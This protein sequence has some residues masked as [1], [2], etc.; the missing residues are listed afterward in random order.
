MKEYHNLLSLCGDQLHI[1]TKVISP[2]QVGTLRK[3]IN[4][5]CEEGNYAIPFLC[6]F[7]YRE[8]I[9]TAEGN[10]ENAVCSDH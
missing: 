1:S 2:K 8:L 3:C 5:V 4:I 10:I 9:F 6:A 7:S